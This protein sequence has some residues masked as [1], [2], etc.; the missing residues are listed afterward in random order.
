M[1]PGQ[2]KP[3]GGTPAW[4]CS[5]VVGWVVLGSSWGWSSSD[6]HL[7]SPTS[8]APLPAPALPRPDHQPRTLGSATQH[9]P[10]VS[11]YRS[12]ASIRGG[13]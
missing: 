8:G 13:H 1:L 10:L 2:G 12:P 7:L 3:R 9:R 11:I 6:L 4:I 5:L